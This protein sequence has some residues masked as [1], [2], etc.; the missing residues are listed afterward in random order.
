[1]AGALLV[2]DIFQ[3][4][5][6]RIFTFEIAYAVLLL[7]GDYFAG[8]AS[9]RLLWNGYAGD[10]IC[11]LIMLPYLMYLVRKWYIQENS[12]NPPTMWI[13]F[14]FIFKLL[15]CLVTSLFL[16]GIATGFVFLLIILIILGLCCLIKTIKEVR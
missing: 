5:K 9:E 4:N 8:T 16:T 3:R 7:F 6:K 10:V 11:A 14:S 12:E 13:R 1:M 2:S 15:V